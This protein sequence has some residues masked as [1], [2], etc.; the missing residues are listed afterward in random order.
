MTNAISTLVGNEVEGEFKWWGS[1]AGADGNVYG[2]PC[3]AR[4]VIKFNPHDNSFVEVGPDI[5]D[6]DDGVKW[7]G[8]VLAGNGCIYCAPCKPSHTDILKIDMIHGTVL[9]LSCQWSGGWAS[10]AL[11][12]DEWIYFMPEFACRRILK[13]NPEDDT[14]MSIEIDVGRGLTLGTLLFSGTVAGNDG[15][16]YG[17]PASLKQIMRFNPVNQT[18]SFV[19]NEAQEPFY[20]RGNG[21]LGRD[22]HIYAARM[23]GSVLKIDVVSNTY[24]IFE[25]NIHE[26]LTLWSLSLGWGAAILGNDGCIY[27][28]PRCSRRTL[29][30]D[31]ETQVISLV[32]NDYGNEDHKWMGGVV[33]SDGVI[34]CMPCSANR[35]L[36]IDPFKEFALS[37]QN[38]IEQYPEELGRLFVMNEHGKTT[39]ESAIIKFGE[40]KVFQVIEDYVPWHVECVGTNLLPFVVAASCENSAVSVIY[41]LLLDVLP[42]WSL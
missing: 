32:G 10:G 38:N 36:A 40:H 23:D 2:I 13:V 30:F 25:N 14:V 15:C 31:P 28:P 7:K 27:W 33:A 4:R 24:S 20:C 39:F 11:A 37:L 21:T 22:G 41:Y 29:K 3:D 5:G 42:N 16:V 19:G 1:L 8:G 9:I 17:I 18:I 34:Y 6:D 26:Y 12:L 35:V